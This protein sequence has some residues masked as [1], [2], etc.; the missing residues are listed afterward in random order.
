MSLRRFQRGLTSVEYAVAGSII[1]AAIIVAM[2]GF[3]PALQ[4]IFAALVAL[5]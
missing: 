3:G 2:V 1:V 4:G 5:I